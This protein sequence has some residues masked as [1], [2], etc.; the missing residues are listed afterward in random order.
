M[1]NYDF[2]QMQ[3][4]NLCESVEFILP[5]DPVYSLTGAK[6]YMDWK[7]KPGQ[8]AVAS[9]SIGKGISVLGEYNFRFD[10]Q[11]ISVPADTY[12][13]DILIV[14][15]RNGIEQPER[16]IGGLVPI[17]SVITKIKK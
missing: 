5:T 16:L 3:E 6:I 17:V 10:E 14:F 12:Q 4:D 15:K 2:D 13:Y 1:Q 9:F 8:L 7:K 11:V